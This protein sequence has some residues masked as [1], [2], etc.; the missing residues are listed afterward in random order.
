[1]SGSQI[2]PV[3]VDVSQLE[4]LQQMAV[5]NNDQISTPSL[6]VLKI[7][8]DD[9]VSVHPK[10]TW[11][12]GQ[13]KNKDGVI[14]DQGKKTIYFVLMK[15]RN[16]YNYY[17]SKNPSASCSSPLIK[18]FEET[19]GNKYKNI[20]GSGCQYRDDKRSPRCSFQMVLFG[21]AI[22]ENKE[23]ILC[24]IYIHGKSFMPTR[25]FIKDLPNMEISGKKYILPVYSFLNK[26]SSIPEKAQGRSYFIA[27]FER[28]QMLPKKDIDELDKMIPD[29]ENV[30]N[31][32]G[33]FVSNYSDQTEDSSSPTDMRPKTDT[34]VDKVDEKEAKQVNVVVESLFEN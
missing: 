23:K 1:M 20:C 26:L 27:N 2:V 22:T 6:P 5:K 34:T 4:E 7:H 32:I 14:T 17:D 10:G 33:N 29:V 31:K 12:L 9:D 13:T 11:V 18:P 24:Q 16:Q 3:N 28:I 30:I 19:R 25:D 15:F 21:L 8:Y